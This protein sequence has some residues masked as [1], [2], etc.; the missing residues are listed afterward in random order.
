MKL[1]DVHLKLLHTTQSALPFDVEFWPRLASGLFLE[2][3]TLHAMLRE[4]SQ[5]GALLGWRGELNPAL[6]E[7]RE[8]LLTGPVQPAGSRLRW[9]GRDEQGAIASVGWLGD[10]NARFCWNSLSCRKCWGRVRP[11]LH[12]GLELLAPDT[13]RTIRMGEGE[14]AALVFGNDAE[15]R[16]ADFLMELRP[17]DLASSPWDTIGAAVGLPPAAAISATKKLLVSRVLRRVAF[18]FSPKGLGMKGC[19]LAGWAFDDSA[20]AQGAAE[21][22]GALEGAMDVFVREPEPN[23]KATLTCLFVG[24]DAGS[25][26]DAARRVGVQWGRAPVMARELEL[27]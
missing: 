9:C 20:D 7:A 4:L 11:T 15:A 8:A 23:S 3:P 1:T 22:L 14:K 27:E 21:G 24:A 17:L 13:D 10:S 25:G 5:A 12:T 16:V 18:R 2:V 6:P 26:M 19:L